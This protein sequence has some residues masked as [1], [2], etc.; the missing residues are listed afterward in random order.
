ML[1]ESNQAAALIPDRRASGLRDGPAEVL[2]GDVTGLG[3]AAYAGVERVEGFEFAGGELEVEDG[4]VL[5]DPLGPHRLGDGAAAFLQVPADHDLGRSLAVGGGDRDDGG[6]VEGAFPAPAVAG[7]AADR[8]PGLGEDPACGVGGQHGRLGEVR[9]HLDLVDRGN[10][11][12]L[13]QQGVEVPG[14][15]VADAD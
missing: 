6:I 5:G 10:D 4:E 8:G 15:E 12:R 14:H 2:Q 13:L 7:D 9:V 11:G 1:K 3:A